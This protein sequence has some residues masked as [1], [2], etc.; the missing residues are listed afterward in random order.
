MGSDEE[1]Q[2]FNPV[3]AMKE[4]EQRGY[5]AINIEDEEEKG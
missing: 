3:T 5:I 4:K 2:M 1:Q